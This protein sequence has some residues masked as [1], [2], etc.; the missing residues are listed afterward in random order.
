M[1]QAFVYPQAFPMTILM[2]KPLTG[3]LRTSRKE[4]RLEA[5]RLARQVIERHDPGFGPF[6]G[7]T[8]VPRIHQL[9]EIKQ[10]DTVVAYY[11]VRW[12]P[13]ENDE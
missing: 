5:Q 11:S 13:G 9:V 4:A 10:Y 8:Q 3:K 2:G 1:W 12:M 6:R 7:G